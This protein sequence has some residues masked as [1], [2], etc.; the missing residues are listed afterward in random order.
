M[1]VLFPLHLE[2]THPSHQSPTPQD[3]NRLKHELAQYSGEVAS[4]KGDNLK[5][6]EK[7]KFLQSYQG[8]KQ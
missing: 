7:I 5:L 8:Q 3:T 6:Y 4:L 1:A 2:L